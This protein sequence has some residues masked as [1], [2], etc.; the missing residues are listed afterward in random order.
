M[1]RNGDNLGAFG[2]L[3]RVYAGPVP[4]LAVGREPRGTSTKEEVVEA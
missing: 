2:D 1:L 3:I 4:C